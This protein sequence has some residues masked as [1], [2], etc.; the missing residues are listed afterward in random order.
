[1]ILIK[2]LSKSFVAS[3]KLCT[4]A[5]NDFGLHFTPPGKS[6]IYINKKQQR[7][8]NWPCGTPARTSPQAKCRPFKIT[9]CFRDFRK[10][11]KILK[12]AH[13][14]HFALIYEGDVYVR[15]C[16]LSLEYLKTHHVLQSLELKIDKFHVLLTKIIIQDSTTRTQEFPCLKPDWF[17]DIKSFSIKKMSTFHSI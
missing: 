16:H 6:L 13:W 5:K 4:V 14:F 12:K 7:A 10:S 17:G 9:L 2:S 1:M 8:K 11:V 3:L 15:H